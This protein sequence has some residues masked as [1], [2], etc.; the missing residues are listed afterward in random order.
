VAVPVFGCDIRDGLMYIDDRAK[1]DAWLKT[2]RSGRYGFTIKEHRE[3]RTSPQNRYYRG[4]VL[5][6]FAEAHG[7]DT[8][9]L[10]YE[11]RRKFLQV[12][13]HTHPPRHTAD[14]NTAEM[15][16]FIDDVRRLA[17]ECGV[18][19]PDPNEIEA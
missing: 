13:D 10:H 12:E 2:R 17:A 11:L 15:T 14:L 8:E 16:R 1:F 9:D 18:A 4:V 3:R 19:I 6:I 5:P 7:W